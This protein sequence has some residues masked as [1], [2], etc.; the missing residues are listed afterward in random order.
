MFLHYIRRIIGDA[1]F[2]VFRDERNESE[3]IFFSSC[4]NQSTLFAKMMYGCLLLFF[5]LT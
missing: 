4:S 5:F 2:S 3:R 1:V